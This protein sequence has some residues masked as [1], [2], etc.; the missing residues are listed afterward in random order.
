MVYIYVISVVV[1]NIL[2]TENFYSFSLLIVSVFNIIT[3]NNFCH[4]TCLCLS[5]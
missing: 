1:F 5:G 4:L 3:Y 2:F